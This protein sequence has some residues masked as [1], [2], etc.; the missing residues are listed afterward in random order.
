MLLF[1]SLS[2]VHVSFLSFLSFFAFL[3][4]LS[5]LFFAAISCLHSLFFFFIFHF[6]LL[7]VP[8][9]F[10]LFL[11]FLIRNKF[12]LNHT[13]WYWRIMRLGKVSVNRFFRMFF[14]IF[15]LFKFQVR[16]VSCIYT[17]FFNK[18]IDFRVDACINILN[19][20]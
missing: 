13:I 15:S 9:H 3:I 6:F 2:L 8:Q 16:I 20:F 11:K 7:F 4:R 1:N 5:S 14:S 17:S 19:I 12:C 18:A 10:F